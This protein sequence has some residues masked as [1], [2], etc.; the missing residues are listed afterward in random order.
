MLKGRGEAGM[1]AAGAEAAVHDE[2]PR[3]ADEWLQLADELLAGMV[4]SLNNRVTALSVCAELV[5]LGDEEIAADGVLPDEVSRLQRAIALIGLIPARGGAAEAMELAPVLDDAIAL[6]A[7]HPRLRDIECVV[8]RTA[9]AV[10]SVQPVRVPRWALLRVLLLMVD[11]AKT[12]AAAARRD[13]V[14][15]HLS[16]DDASVT[17]RTITPA[18]GRGG[19]YAASMASRC[20]G[21]VARE[22][23]EMVLTL[24][25]LPE[26]RRRERA[27]SAAV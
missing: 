5:M 13:R 23:E 11:A 18:D 7:H 22:G 24:P 12:A 10:G 1:G 3:G 20:G 14:V 16:S 17:V 25:S 19:L 6:H 27:A 9:G 2:R 4:H 26:V 8:D 21:T 15:L